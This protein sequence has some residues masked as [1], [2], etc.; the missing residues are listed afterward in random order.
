MIIDLKEL[1]KL[2]QKYRNDNISLNALHY[3]IQTVTSYNEADILHKP[4][5]AIDTLIELGVVKTTGTKSAEHLN[6]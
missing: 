5:L 4:G 1:A 6:S 3:M 2:E